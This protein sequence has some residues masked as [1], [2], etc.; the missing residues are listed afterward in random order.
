MFGIIL[1]FGA[2]MV[3][4]SCK[5]DD[6]SADGAKADLQSGTWK[7]TFLEDDGQNETYHFSGYNFTFGANGV[8]TASNGTQNVTGS[9]SIQQDSDHVELVLNFGTNEPWDE[10]QDDWHIIKQTD[11]KF[12]LEDVS[13]DGSVD[14][15]TFEKN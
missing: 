7:I 10:L 3:T 13:G 15:L 11:K 6:V 5:K 8:A 9:W 2:V 4:A 1:V 12:E 14:K